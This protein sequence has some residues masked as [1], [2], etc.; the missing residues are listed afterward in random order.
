MSAVRAKEDSLTALDISETQIDQMELPEMLMINV[1]EE[2]SEWRGVRRCNVIFVGG[3][4][5]GEIGER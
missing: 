1:L 2:A 3:K 4:N 5:C